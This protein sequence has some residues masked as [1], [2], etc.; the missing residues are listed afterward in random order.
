MYPLEPGYFKRRL[1]R[2]IRNLR[3]RTWLDIRNPR[4]YLIV[5]FGAALI[6]S[7]FFHAAGS[8]GVENIRTLH[9]TLATAEASVL[10][11][12][13]SVTLVAIQVVSNKYSSRLPQIFL[14]EPLFRITFGT[15][16]IGIGLNGVAIFFAGSLP[17]TVANVLVG[18]A[19]SLA[20]IGFY[21][22]Y[23]LIR[24]MIELGS[25]EELI[26]AIGKFAC[27]EQL[28]RQACT[29][30]DAEPAIHPT[31]PL[32]NVILRGFE[33]REYE[34]A[35]R[36]IIEFR[37]VLLSEIALL[38]A[39]ED[40]TSASELADEIFETPMAEYFS[41]ILLEAFDEHEELI[42]VTTTAYERIVRNAIHA[43]YDDVAIHASE[44]LSDA[45]EEAPD[46]RQGKS[47]RRPISDTFLTL[48]KIA[49]GATRFSTF[50][51]M[52]IKFHVV[53]EHFINRRPEQE[54]VD[55][56]LRNY[57][58]QGGEEIFE[59]L[60]HRYGEGVSEPVERWV[61]PY[62]QSTRKISAEAEQLRFFWR[63]WGAL[64]KSLIHYRQSTGKD[65]IRG[66]SV[67]DSWSGF[68][69]LADENELPGLA[70][71][72]C[73]SMIKSAYAMTVLDGRV[74]A[75]VVNTLANLQL[76]STGAPVGD[77]FDALLDES[78]PN[79]GKVPTNFSTPEKGSESQ[80]DGL[81]G[82]LGGDTDEPP[83]FEEWCQALQQQVA[84]RAE[85]IRDKR[86]EA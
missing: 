66:T 12:A 34:T 14:K 85:Y 53:I 74:P 77:A 23:R 65:A 64:T 39:T 70:T 25:P 51:K 11:I 76:D 8:A 20:T 18:S 7:L 60:V 38:Q 9:S 33:L 24:R 82:F 3:S 75:F 29:G 48:L 32:Y 84:E 4:G 57:Y 63:Q 37:E 62:P 22:L 35:R 49:A 1:D 31:H 67:V 59:E 27:N 86:S 83:E 61:E 68:V 13:L 56:T 81:F 55:A 36:G 73:M 41:S 16:A 46:T 80:S 28:I 78:I 69:E 19:F 52:M 45:M 79:R 50:R 10:A 30:A 43:G 6:Y 40:A 47:L 71:L 54:V 5:L 44:G 21:A 72:F 58:G 26:P 2:I 17:V 42:S 15:L